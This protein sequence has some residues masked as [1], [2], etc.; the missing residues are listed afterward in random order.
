MGLPLPPINNTGGNK[1]GAN[2]QGGNERGA[3]DQGGN[4]EGANDQGGNEEGATEQVAESPN[5][6]LQLDQLEEVIEVIT[7]EVVTLAMGY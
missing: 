6:F 1:R 5:M 3:N 7:Y 4:E 2:D